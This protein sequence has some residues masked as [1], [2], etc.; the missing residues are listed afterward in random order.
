MLTLQSSQKDT[1]D[2]NT[3]AQN[4][5]EKYRKFICEGAVFIPCRPCLYRHYNFGK[6]A[7]EQTRDLIDTRTFP[8]SQSKRQ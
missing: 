4:K 7:Y 6:K 3:I 8:D 5:D 1:H 2:S